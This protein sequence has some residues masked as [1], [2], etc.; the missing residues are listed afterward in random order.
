M[1]ENSLRFFHE[2][3]KYENLIDSK[4][5]SHVEFLIPSFQ[6]IGS[7]MAENTE[8]GKKVDKCM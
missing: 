1:K 7:A 3:G 8:I 5:K 6:L 2:Y 4:G